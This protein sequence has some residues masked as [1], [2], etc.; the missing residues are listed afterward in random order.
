[1]EIPVAERRLVELVVLLKCQ[2][3]LIKN[4]KERGND[5]SSA[6][7]VFDSLRVGFFLAAQDWHRALCYSE[8]EAQ[9]HTPLPS[10]RWGSKSGLYVPLLLSDLAKWTGSELLE[11]KT[12]SP[13]TKDRSDTTSEA[14]QAVT[15]QENIPSGDAFDFRPLTENEKK[16]FGNLLDVE[17]GHELEEMFREE[18]KKSFE[19][20]KMPFKL[21]MVK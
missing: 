1:M 3:R 10:I 6:K 11:H 16:D 20:R 8:Q 14:F 13:V 15:E 7:N 4:L 21:R 17:A 19:K 2:L 5:F 18:I 9:N 12:V